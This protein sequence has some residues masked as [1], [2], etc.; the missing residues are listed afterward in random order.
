MS[1]SLVLLGIALIAFILVDALWTTVIPHGGGPLTTLMCRGLWSA[2][3]RSPAAVRKLLLP[4]MGS[5]CLLTVIFTWVVLLWLGWWVL[6]SADP[7]SVLHSQTD[8]PADGWGRV[9][10]TGFTLFTLGVGDYIPNDTFWQLATALGSFNGLFLIT[11]S[12]TYLLPVLSAATQKRQLA[13]MIRDLGSDPSALV[14]ESWN[15]DGFDPLAQRLT[16]D[17]WPMIHLH[18][19]RHLAYPILHYFHSS[20]AENSLAVCIAALDEA[21]TLLAYGV[22]EQARPRPWALALTRRAIGSL[23]EVLEGRFIRGSDDTPPIPDL[24][25]LAAAGIPVTDPDAFHREVEKLANRRR[26]LRGLVED[27][28]WSWHNV[29]ASTTQPSSLYT[30]PHE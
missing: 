16:T 19:Q 22:A 13:A 3:K 26:R 6:F 2:A 7:S 23:L 25:R 10:Y 15:G 28:G 24:N 29:T 30:Q 27:A 14:V 20:R 1:I 17:I 8:L 18:V 5:V 11:L 4:V 21:L 12:I 9:Y